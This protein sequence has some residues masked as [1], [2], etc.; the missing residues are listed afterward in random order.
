MT[1]P[2]KLTVYGDPA[3]QGSKIAHALPSG[4]I[5]MREV[6]KKIDPW[7]RAVKEAVLSLV[8]DDFE[9]FDSPLEIETIFYLQ[10]GS[11]IKRPMPT[12]APDLDKLDRGL[13]DALTQAGVWRDDALVVSSIS[14]KLYADV[15]APG[16]EV[17]IRTVDF[18][19]LAIVA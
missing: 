9:P 3:P 14:T 15:R 17:I 2:F 18:I 10:R 5:V 1:T 13:W 7:R 19:P 4:K 8:G 16:V 12:V 6:S 11:S